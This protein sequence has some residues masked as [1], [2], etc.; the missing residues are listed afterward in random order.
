MAQESKREILKD[1]V[2]KLVKEFVA[3]EGGITIFDLYALFGL[4]S[5]T[6]DFHEVATA[7]AILPISVVRI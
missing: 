7:L 1:Q 6:D 3:S 5:I 2:V 4:P